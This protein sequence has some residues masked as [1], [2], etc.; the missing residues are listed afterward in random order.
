[1]VLMGSSPGGLLDLE[2]C[3]HPPAPFPSTDNILSKLLLHKATGLYQALSWW[4]VHSVVSEGCPG[5]LLLGCLLSCQLRQLP[6]C[7]A[8]QPGTQLHLCLY[9]WLGSCYGSAL[10]PWPPP[11]TVH[12]IALWLW[13]LIHTDSTFIHP[14]CS[15]HNLLALF[16]LASGLLCTLSSSLMSCL[17]LT[18][19]SWSSCHLLG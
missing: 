1:M 2:G 15:T 19:S 5:V 11:D 14:P 12:F 7:A 6:Q 8:A 18:V 16:R 13:L 10:V 3:Y 17:L 4:S 9:H